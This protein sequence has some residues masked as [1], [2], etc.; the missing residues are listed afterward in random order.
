MRFEL[1]AGLFWASVCTIVVCGVSLWAA[2]L[3]P[4]FT[5][6]LVASGLANPTTMAFAPDG[7]LFVL[8][9]AGR[10]R[11]I[12]N[13]TLLPT[14]FTTLT[15]DSAGERGLLGIA[16]DP[17]FLTSPQKYVYLYYTATTP[18]VHN[19]VSRFTANGNVAVAGS[20]L[21]ILDLE[22]LSSATNHNGGALH[23][24]PDGHLYVAVG[25]NA[26]GANA[27]TLANRLGK[28][29]RIAADGSIP[30][31]NPFVS[32]TAGAMRAI[33]ALGLR[34]PYTFAFDPATAA[35]YINDVGQSTWEEVNVGQA[36]ANY[37][38]PTTEGPTTNPNFTSPLYAYQHSAGTVRGCAISG[39]A[40][41]NGVPQQFPA[42]YQGDYFFADFCS[43][44]INQLDVA[45]QIV[46]PTFAT[47]VTARPV[48]VRVGPDGALYYLA[49]GTGATTG[50]VHRIAYA[51]PPPPTITSHP[52][53]Q[54]VA[55]GQSATFTVSA[56]GASPL[57]YQ[58]QRNGV[59]I[60][61][62]TQSTYTLQNASASDD[63]GLFRVWVSD[64]GGTS[65]SNAARLTVTGGGAS[66]LLSDPGFEAGGA[67]WQQVTHTG[68]GI[69]TTTPHSGVNALQI[70]ASAR[71][72]R[73]V[74]QSVPVTANTSYTASGWIRTQGM[75]SGASVLL[76][77]HTAANAVI[78]TDVVGSLTATSGWVERSAAFTAPANAA[79]VVL[80]VQTAREPDDV[81][82][83]WFDDLA[84]APA[85]AVNQAPVVNAGADRVTQSLTLALDATVTDDGQPNGT[86][87]SMWSLVS[88]P[89]TVT[90]ADATAVDTSATFSVAGTYVLRL[91]ASDG[92]LAGVDEVTVQAGAAPVN[93]LANPGFEQGGTGWQ[94]VAHSGRSVVTSPVHAGNGALQTTVSNRYRREVDQVVA[95]AGNTGYTVAGWI[96]TQGLTGGASLVVEWRT[97][98]NALIRT[99][100]VGSLTGTV[101]WTLRSSTLTSP[102]NAAEAV[103]RVQTVQE[104][105]GTGFGWFDDLVFIA[106]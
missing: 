82:L 63:G 35:M 42:A 62:A 61:G 104:P 37:G 45:G 74:T 56:S 18:T 69:V 98:G 10:V 21:P 103:V 11:V 97:S 15:V 94:Y 3:R 38:W 80:R 30:P 99:D 47:N 1:R 53:D 96:R 48:D 8:E 88:G 79:S 39:A 76:E 41:Y 46:T 66:N 27:Q 52:Q 92:Q 57:S 67:G 54:T 106:Q 83:A 49:R 60:S 59:D 95:V 13:G 19:R 73:E 89:G 72:V 81:G 32:Q 55:A 9:Q 78:R 43:G 84:L 51:A 58:W 101:D 87:N 70:T 68:R 100:V 34:N 22:T 28:I 26:N 90:F 2:V 86:L 29:L 85:A 91:T 40:F 71:Y 50:A 75:S 16:F 4:G 12:E 77:W 44:W 36:G 65:I 64:S 31:D 25:D 17:A 102:V 7:R 5:E 6:T 93:L 33:W 24:G 20:E 14:P 23:F 105:D